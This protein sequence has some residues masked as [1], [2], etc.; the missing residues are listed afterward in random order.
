M[1]EGFGE[2]IGLAERT[3]EESPH[4]SMKFGRTILLEST[5][6]ELLLESSILKV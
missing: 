2:S 6:V 3:K 5:F 1:F 4:E